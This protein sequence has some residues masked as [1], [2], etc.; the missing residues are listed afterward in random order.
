MILSIEQK[1]QDEA[2]D[3]ALDTLKLGKQALVFVNTK[4]HLS[5]PRVIIAPPEI[6]PRNLAGIATL[7][8]SSTL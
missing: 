5:K 2:I 7:P 4:R 3:L 8:F 6:L 1:T